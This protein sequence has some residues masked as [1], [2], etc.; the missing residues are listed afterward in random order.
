MAAPAVVV[1]WN[2]RLSGT[3][4]FRL[5]NDVTFSDDLPHLRVHQTFGLSVSLS[6]LH[7]LQR[8]SLSRIYS[9]RAYARSRLGV[10]GLREELFISLRIQYTADY[11]Q[12]FLP[13]PV[14]AHDMHEHL[15]GAHS[16]VGAHGH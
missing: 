9:R 16:I 13:V 1:V 11:T 10:W 7:V 3:D 14:H 5:R 4:A 8:P 6:P 12:A 2:S 15:A